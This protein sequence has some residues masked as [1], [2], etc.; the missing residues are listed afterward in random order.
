[1]NIN[2]QYDTLLTGG[3]MNYTVSEYANKM[4]VTP[5][6]VRVWIRAGKLNYELSPSGRKLITGVKIER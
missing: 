1:L 4:R 5:K 3:N 2:E 6:T